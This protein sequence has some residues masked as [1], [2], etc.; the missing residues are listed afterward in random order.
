MEHNCKK[1]VQVYTMWD[2]S[3]IKL[4][5]YSKR[6]FNFIIKEEKIKTRDNKTPRSPD[7][8]LNVLYICIYKYGCLRRESSISTGLCLDEAV[9]RGYCPLVAH[10]TQPQHKLTLW[11][12]CF[13]TSKV[14]K[15]NKMKK[16]RE[17][18]W[19]LHL[20]AYTSL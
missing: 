3:W 11:Y 10:G 12:Y 5:Y 18:N 9:Y 17:K 6:Q 14:E 19:R 16:Q 1:T 4:E 7:C 20:Q 2:K 15:R 8:Q 13:S